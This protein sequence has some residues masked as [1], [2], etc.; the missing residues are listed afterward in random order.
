M[1]IKKLLKAGLARY[2]EEHKST[3]KQP[4]GHTGSKHARGRT[5]P[6][7]WHRNLRARRKQQKLARRAQRRKR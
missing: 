6:R 4:R 2:V 3:P 5:R 7:T 1:N